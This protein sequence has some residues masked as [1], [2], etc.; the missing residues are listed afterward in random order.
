MDPLASR[1]PYFS[2]N[3]ELFVEHTF[4]QDLIIE[5]FKWIDQPNTIKNCALTCRGWNS[6]IPDSFHL[7][8]IM[9]MEN[10]SFP[11]CTLFKATHWPSR[12]LNLPM[13]NENWKTAGGKF[14]YID[15][16]T[17]IFPFPSIHPFGCVLPSE[18]DLIYTST[19]L[20]IE[21]YIVFGNHDDT[22]FLK[23]FDNSDT[24]IAAKN[25]SN[26]SEEETISIKE[27]NIFDASTQEEQEM[28]GTWCLP[29]SKRQVAFL[30]YFLNIECFNI[31]D[32][33][34]HI[35]AS[36]LDLDQKTTIP[37][38]LLSAEDEEIERLPA[39]ELMTFS[40]I[41]CGNH[42]IFNKVIIDLQ[43][44]KMMT[45]GFELRGHQI[46]ACGA[47]FYPVDDKNPHTIAA[48][49]ISSQGK[50]EKKW[51]IEKLKSHKNQ[52]GLLIEAI[53]AND[54]FIALLCTTLNGSFQCI[55]LLD[56]EG[57]FV[58]ETELFNED[59]VINMHLVKQLLIN[60][61]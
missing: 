36:L 61:R 15:K 39:E 38:K 37:K 59:S 57:K 45:H 40:P 4:N 35:Q 32:M 60:L 41:Q 55:H 9:R 54:K 19:D 56:N 33:K 5:I 29:L 58:S 52:K 17:V 13:S 25:L 49:C 27:V 42:I 30:S 20:I 10:F 26:P 8:F 28:S 34:I 31:R 1:L 50:L 48:Y 44:F 23:P 43:N 46:A 2:K 21:N 16:E 51:D 18:K 14:Y 11:I 6:V 3:S 24:L 47:S 22:Y 53:Q 12:C 7:R